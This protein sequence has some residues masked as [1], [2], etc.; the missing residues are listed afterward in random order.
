MTARGAVYIHFNV[1]HIGVWHELKKFQSKELIIHIALFDDI[2]QV[3][4]NKLLLLSQ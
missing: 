1:K 3:P 2:Y 4:V